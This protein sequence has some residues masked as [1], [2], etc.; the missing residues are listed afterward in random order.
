MPIVLL[1]KLILFKI[2][3]IEV[4][5]SKVISLNI[6]VGEFIAI[7]ELVVAANLI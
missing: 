2:L 1:Y 7:V 4:A 3:I 5:K 6:A